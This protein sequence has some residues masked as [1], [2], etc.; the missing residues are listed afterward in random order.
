MARPLILPL[1]W[2]QLHQALCPKA[3]TLRHNGVQ[4]C[5]RAVTNSNTTTSKRPFHNTQAR[6]AVGPPRRSPSVRM[7]ERKGTGAVSGDVLVTSNGQG[8]DRDGFWNRYCVAHVE[9]TL[10]EFKEFTRQM[11]ETY[12]YLLPPGVNMAT[13]G[14]V[15]EQLIRLSHSRFPSAS[16]I[17][18]I[19]VDADAVYRISFVLRTLS[20]GRYIYQWALTGCAKAHSRRALVD[21]V[22]QYIN[23]EGVDIYR[24]SEPIAQ[25]KDLALKDEFPQ[26][27]MLYAKLLIW[28]GEHGQAAR[29]LEQKILPYLQPVSTPPPLWEDIKL[30]DDFE[31]PWRMYAI[32]VEKEQGLQ[33]ILNATRRAA[34]EFHDP[35][36]MTDYAISVLETDEPHKYEVYESYM[37]AAAL[38]QHPLACFYLANLYYRI[39]QGEFTT[40]AE[41]DAKKREATYAQRRAWLRRF[42][43]IE[44]WVNTLFNQPLDRKSY[45]ILAMDWYELA[46][47]MGNNE[48]GYILALLLREDG[49]MERSRE[50]YNLTAQMGLPTSL[51]K[52]GLKLMED[53]WEDQTFKP[54]PPP[55]LL[56]LA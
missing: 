53:K 46:F 54:G 7:Q 13:F 41:R 48:S 23:I 12:D 39:S 6:S 33:G 21:L 27:I 8:L 40:E 51:S 18:S 15:G 28:R 49:E 42:E 24:N 5:A 1:Q 34:L 38:G 29:L 14:S 26:A 45:R 47:D 11:Y 56:R 22:N 3:H 9:P 37:A 32:A 19:S 2:R 31:S 35:L 30:L 10:A 20:K 44:K 36:A 25:I 17:R 43:P 52:K 50:V 55:Q 4:A 16:L